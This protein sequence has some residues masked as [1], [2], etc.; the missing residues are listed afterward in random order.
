MGALHIQA[1]AITPPPV[2]T[3]AHSHPLF[4]QLAGGLRVDEVAPGE[5]VIVVRSPGCTGLLRDD[6]P[7]RARVAA[8]FDWSGDLGWA[9]SASVDD[10]HRALLDGTRGDVAFDELRW[11]RALDARGLL[12]RVPPERVGALRGAMG[13]LDDRDR[14]AFIAG[15]AEH[16]A[17][18]GDRANLVLLVQSLFDFV[19]FQS[20]EPL[21]LMLDPRQPAEQG[22]L[23]FARVR[24]AMILDEEPWRAA[25][26]AR[27]ADHVAYRPGDRSGSVG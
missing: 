23:A 6:P 9:A 8:A 17:R 21:L 16:L 3:D 20:L 1:L 11:R 14:R 4:V 26:L 18:T 12:A 22:P 2:A 10:L 19:P 13:R 25:S 5:R 15:A 27:L 7:T 24:I